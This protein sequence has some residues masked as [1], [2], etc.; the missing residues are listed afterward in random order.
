MEWKSKVRADWVAPSPEALIP[1]VVESTNRVETPE[2]RRPA[3]LRLPGGI[4][5]DGAV[6]VRFL[7]RGTGRARVTY[8]AEKGGT[9][10]L[11]ADVR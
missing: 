9:A 4:P 5:G 11:E 1:M 6:R 7:V 2:L 10:T 3:A 8:R